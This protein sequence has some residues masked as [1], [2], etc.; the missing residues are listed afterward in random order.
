MTS[1]KNYLLYAILFYG[2]LL[3]AWKISILLFYATCDSSGLEI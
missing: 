2:W 3:D 1:Q